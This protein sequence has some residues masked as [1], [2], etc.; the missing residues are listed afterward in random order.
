MI[1]YKMENAVVL[2]MDHQ[3]EQLDVM[4]KGM[5]SL[6]V[7]YGSVSIP[8]VPMDAF[9]TLKSYLQHCNTRH[10]AHVS[11]P[12]PPLMGLTTLDIKTLYDTTNT[13]SNQMI[14]IVKWDG[15][16]SCLN[17]YIPNDI[18]TAVVNCTMGGEER[19]HA[20]KSM[21]LELMA[22]HIPV[23]VVCS[24]VMTPEQTQ[25]LLLL[26]QAV[27]PQCT[28][29]YMLFN[30]G[31]FTFK[32][33]RSNPFF[34]HYYNKSDW[35]EQPIDTLTRSVLPWTPAIW[36]LVLPKL[37]HDALR[38]ILSVPAEQSLDHTIQFVQTMGLSL[39][40][41]RHLHQ[42]LLF[43]DD[44]RGGYGGGMVYLYN[45]KQTKTFTKE[46]FGVFIEYMT[47]L[48]ERRRM[49]IGLLHNY[50]LACCHNKGLS[51]QQSKL[52]LALVTS[53]D[54]YGENSEWYP[55]WRFAIF[56]FVIKTD[57][58]HTGL[59]YASLCFQ[60]VPRLLSLK[61]NKDITYKPGWILPCQF[62]F[63]QLDGQFP[64]ATTVFLEADQHGPRV[65]YRDLAT[66]FMKERSAGPEAASRSEEMVED[67][68]SASDVLKTASKEQTVHVKYE[69]MDV[70]SIMV[71][72]RRKYP[73][74]AFP[75]KWNT[76]TRK[77]E[78]LMDPK[79]YTEWVKGLMDRYFYPHL[80]ELCK[81][82][83]IPAFK[84]P[85]RCEH[86]AWLLVTVM[87]GI[88]PFQKA[89]R[90]IDPC[91]FGKDD[92]VMY[93]SEMMILMYMFLREQPRYV[94]LLWTR[95]FL[96]QNISAQ[97]QMLRGGPFGLITVDIIQGAIG[98]DE[99]GR[100]AEQFI[101]CPEGITDRFFTV[102][103]ELFDSQYELYDTTV[104]IDRHIKYKLKSI[105]DTYQSWKGHTDS[106][107][108][109]FLNDVYDIIKRDG[110][111]HN[112][113]DW[114]PQLLSARGYYSHLGFDMTS[115]VEHVFL[116]RFYKDQTHTWLK[117]H[118]STAFASEEVLVKDM[119]NELHITASTL[120]IW[121]MVLKEL[122]SMYHH[123][124]HFAL[125]PIDIDKVFATIPDSEQGKRRSKRRFYKKVKK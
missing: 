125:A 86:V 119:Y 83:Q 62:P 74:Y 76:E 10:I 79:A 90:V 38:A 54:Y 52:L 32:V 9:P 66:M 18:S 108:E 26:I 70:H 95:M 8:H 40:T 93:R 98:E 4:K 99:A 29:D 20:L 36:S 53:S 5:E 48:V 114:I 13:V 96:T 11:Y 15:V 1:H 22:R 123:T 30:S 39:L 23:F 87:K 89:H 122:Q 45:P 46:E 71:A 42:F 109:D 64:P 68:R 106:T 67:G 113:L 121:I 34:L 111:N 61:D 112:P 100:L 101:S 102:F 28:M 88:L 69:L 17:G 24:S 91:S 124:F 57:L 37:D 82:L 94:Q 43:E 118:E 56:P 77:M 51:H 59:S 49:S 84:I 60:K 2:Y 73:E 80:V 55:L 41:M 7:R 105:I 19:C 6:G 75:K 31:T 65:T 50:L 117:E 12:D 63:L 81:E 97:E 47:F 78:V 85:Q 120:P 44:I 110:R 25:Q 35:T 104:P 103:R 3:K 58:V 21:F 72:L 14:V 92:G 33:V 116:Y 107:E 115:S 27:I 16:V